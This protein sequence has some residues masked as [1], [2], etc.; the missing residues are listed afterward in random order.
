MKIASLAAGILAVILYLLCF[1]FKDAGKILVCK[2]FSSVLYVLQYLLLFAFVGA[3]M[4]FS[5]LISSWLAYRKDTPFI[6]KHR[7]PVLILLH[8]GILTVGILLYESPVSLLAIAGVLFESAAGWMRTEK[9]IRI[10]SLFATPCWFTYNIVC[11]AYGSALGSVLACASI[12]TALI[13]YAGGKTPKKTVD[14][15]EKP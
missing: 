2:I 7:I 4:D 10:V 13:R 9:R 3:A 6:R 11:G 5:A 14:L 15:P 1:Q 8:A 12:V